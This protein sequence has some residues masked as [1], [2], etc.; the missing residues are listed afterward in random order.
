LREWKFWKIIFNIKA[1]IKGRPFASS[2]I[3]HKI[4]KV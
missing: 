4:V 2:Q 1:M 3:L